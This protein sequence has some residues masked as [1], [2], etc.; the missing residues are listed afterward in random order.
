[1]LG[2][3][4]DQQNLIDEFSS[5][6]DWQGGRS[7]RVARNR[8]WKTERCLIVTCQMGYEARRT[9]KGGLQRGR[10]CA[11]RIQGDDR[12]GTFAKETKAQ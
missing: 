5:G 9:G 6:T 3:N 2:L 4:G 7:P 1:M 10:R 8:T 11:L 12:D